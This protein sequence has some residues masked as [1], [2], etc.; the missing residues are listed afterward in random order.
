[1]S[2]SLVSTLQEL[3]KAQSRDSR[4]TLGVSL[5]TMMTAPFAIWAG[6]SML[7]L[8][9]QPAF[10]YWNGPSAFTVVLITAYLLGFASLWTVISILQLRVAYKWRTKDKRLAEAY[11]S[12]L[13]E[14]KGQ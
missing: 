12:L 14:V 10:I 13:E 2:D 4:I 8:A 11:K 1:M 5:V 7:T 3:F 6:G 9:S